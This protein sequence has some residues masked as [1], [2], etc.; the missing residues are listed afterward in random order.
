MK[1][2]LKKTLYT[3]TGIVVLSVTSCSDGSIKKEQ[4]IIPGFDLAQLDTTVSPTD[5]FF[6][7]ATGGWKK[8]NPIPETESR[9]GSFN[10]LYEDGQT[11]LKEII[12]NAQKKSSPKG[13]DAQLIGD[14]YASA[15]DSLQVEKLGLKP[16][17]PIL[18]SIKN[19]KSYT[20]FPEFFAKNDLE[21]VGYSPIP[22]YIYI[23]KKSSN[24][25]IAYTSQGGLTLPDRDY[26]IKNDERFK[27]IRA[28]Y[29]KH[30]QK[31]FVLVGYN[32]KE[33]KEKAN[34]VF[35]I[36]KEIAVNSMSRIE[37]R[38]P[39]VTY[40]KKTIE[41]LQK[42]SPN[43]DWNKYFETLDINPKEIIV[44]QV[45][46]L[47]HINK[48]FKK[49]PI[50]DW[51]TYFEWHVVTGAAP[52]LPNA[53]VKE[54]FHFFS[55]IM[56]GTEKMKSREKRSV[57][58]VNGVL[59][60]PLGKLFVAKYFPESSK[61]NV[62]ELVENLRIAYIDRVKQLDWM[63]DETKSKAI[64]KLKAFTYKIGYPSK[65]KDYSS[66][67]IDSKSVLENIFA[68]SKWETQDNLSKLGKPVDK[69]EWGMTPQTVNAYYNP[70]NN[71]IVFPAGILQP[72]FYSPNTDVAINYGA[73]GGV[74]GHEFSHGFDDSGS[75]YDENGNLNDWWTK[76]DRAKFDAKTSV[77]VKQFDKYEPLPNVF[78]QGELTLGE[79]IADLGGLTLGYYALQKYYEKNGGREI[80]AGFT[81]EQRF[82][83]GW[84]QVWAQNTR[85]EY[86]KKQVTTDPHS[87]AQYRVNGPMSNLDEFRKAWNAKEGDNMVRTGDLQAKIW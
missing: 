6:Q 54:N 4:N 82:Y 17:Q 86:I 46:F 78:V 84:A 31:M 28:E 26:Y 16:L 9:W 81:P 3:I 69:T 52:W 79:N 2:I 21:G 34:T 80:L 83:L 51:K 65:W 48:Q 73:I 61:K 63:S 10:I 30:L 53:F 77:V 72:P 66:I 49:T 87:P 58:M 38:N 59:G 44:S 27:K 11:K 33:A 12:L 64:A 24:E 35:S 29:K 7:F 37:R 60:N 56:N 20:D 36:E 8:L 32:E 74:I 85:D 22:F 68:V 76:E 75:K 45:D 57:R 25:N 13:S 55:N 18:N 19:L 42:I 5:N 15:M 39:E 41:Q 47:S 50:E 71:E 14:F 62:E 70:V 1:S 67:N 40:N 23:D 43:Y